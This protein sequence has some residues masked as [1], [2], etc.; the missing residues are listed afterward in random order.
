MGSGASYV[1]NL[2]PAR[3]LE[4]TAGS[5]TLT[6][7]AKTRFM[8]LDL[9]D[10]YVRSAL[11]SSVAVATWTGPPSP[12]LESTC[13]TRRKVPLRPAPDCHAFYITIFYFI[14]CPLATN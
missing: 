7:L 9:Y 12:N 4:L 11:D 1:P 5:A 13:D 2:V 3:T 8:G 6:H 14:R 10:S